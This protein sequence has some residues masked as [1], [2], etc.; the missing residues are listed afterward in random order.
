MRQGVDPELSFSEWDGPAHEVPTLEVAV[1]SDG[2]VI[3]ARFLPILL[4]RRGPGPTARGRA[5]PKRRAASS[6]ASRRGPPSDDPDL[7][8]PRSPLS[9]HEREWLKGEVDRR[10]RQGIADQRIEDRA[11]FR[12]VQAW[13][14]AEV[15]A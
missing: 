4:Q 14:S 13:G 10:V 6:A 5:A 1:N 8:P 7:D 12:A 3:A 9:P 2:A 11:L 15:V